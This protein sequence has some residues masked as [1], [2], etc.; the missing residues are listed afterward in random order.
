M[1]VE[2]FIRRMVQLNSGTGNVPFIKCNVNS[3]NTFF[4]LIERTI[5]GKNY[6]TNP[7]LFSRLHRFKDKN[8]EEKYINSYNGKKL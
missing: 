6:T 7:N 8:L 2:E 5:F 1:T 4:H 3:V